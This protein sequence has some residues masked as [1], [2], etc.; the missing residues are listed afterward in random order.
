MVLE[1]GVEHQ[2][3]AVRIPLVPLDD[4]GEHG[5][6]DGLVVS[7]GG[8]L[9][10]PGVPG[11]GRPALGRVLE[12]GGVERVLVGEVLEDAGL[13]DSGGIG[14]APRGRALEP[15]IGEQLECDVDDLLAAG[16]GRETP[17][18]GGRRGGRPAGAGNECQS[19]LELRSA[20]GTRPVS[21]H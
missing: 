14:D 18:P 6:D 3:Q 4:A 17:R 5:A 7:A 9:V 8:E 2:A 11:L 16:A 13:G 12:D 19:G 1:R 20:T 10:E 15:A 21:V